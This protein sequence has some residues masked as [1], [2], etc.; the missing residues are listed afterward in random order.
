M[1]TILLNAGNSSPYVLTTV[2]NTTHG[3][4][5]LPVI[6]AGSDLTI[7]GYGDTIQRS[8]A[9][10]TAAFRLFLTGPGCFSGDSVVVFWDRRH[11]CLDSNTS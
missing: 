4:T 8:T 2:D 7:L 11:F 3:A 10:G 9:E 5:G 1:N 6:I